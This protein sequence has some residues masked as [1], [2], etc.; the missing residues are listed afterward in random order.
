M[1]QRATKEARICRIKIQERRKAY[2][3][4]LSLASTFY[5]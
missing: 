4:S 1:L 3:M 2:S 5:L